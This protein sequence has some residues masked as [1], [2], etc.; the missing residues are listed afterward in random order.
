[1]PDHLP[2]REAIVLDGGEVD[3]GER[4]QNLLRQR[5]LDGDLG[6]AVGLVLDLDVALAVGELLQVGEV[7]VGVR[8]VD[9]QQVLVVGHAM[10]QQVVDEG[11]LRVHQPGV[12]GP[13]NGE[14]G[15]VVAR[16]ELDEAEGAGAAHED[17]THVRHVEEARARTHAGAPR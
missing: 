17:L 15:V 3:R 6:P 12:L 8:G 7:L 14:L 5:T 11:P 9:H 10:D 1:V 2:P 4:L 16:D 13:P